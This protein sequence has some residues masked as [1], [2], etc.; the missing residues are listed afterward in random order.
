MRVDIVLRW[1][2]VFSSSQNTC[3]SILSD[4][5]RAGTASALP[6]NL[7]SIQKHSQSLPNHEEAFRSEQAKNKQGN[8]IKR[9]R[10]QLQSSSLQTRFQMV[11]SQEQHTSIHTPIHQQ[12]ASYPQQQNQHQQNAHLNQPLPT[13]PPQRP[14]RPTTADEELWEAPPSQEDAPIRGFYQSSSSVSRNSSYGSLPPGASPPLPSSNG[15]RSPSP[16]FSVSTVSLNPTTKAN[17]Q[18][19]DRDF[20]QQPHVLRKRPQTTAPV[21]LGIL[22]ALDPPRNELPKPA[23]EE[24]P[25]TSS[26]Y[27]DT[28]HRDREREHADKKD[29]WN[30]WNRDKEKERER[31]KEKERQKP[32]DRD[33]ERGREKDRSGDSQNELTRMIGM[34]PSISITCRLTIPVAAP[35]VF[36]FNCIRR[37]G[38]RIGGL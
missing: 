21:A 4:T 34:L 36:E 16:P 1:A 24:R 30:F 2:G 20:P 17:P 37:L 26:G 32:H 31:E 5:A 38:S 35:R 8:R 25:I 29:K 15:P 12:L 6:M 13:L 33:K 11:P 27:S 18:T 10:G 14:Q 23:Y 3:A 28:G 22:R 9:F 7:Y 19:R